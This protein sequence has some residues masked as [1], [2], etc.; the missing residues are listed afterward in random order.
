[1]EIITY[2]IS[3][4]VCCD[5]IECVVTSVVVQC[6]VSLKK[7]NV[8]LSLFPSMPLNKV[9]RLL[10]LLYEYPLYVE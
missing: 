9:M 10:A 5:F 4:V 8:G 2:G 1:M 7:Q 3:T 6:L